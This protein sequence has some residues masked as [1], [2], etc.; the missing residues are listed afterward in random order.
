MEREK[1]LY[2]FVYRMLL[3]SIYNGTYKCK[4][5]LPSLAQ[6]CKEYKVGRNTIRCAL[7]QLQEDGYI[8]M[9]KGVQALVVFNVQDL[10]SNLK[11][12]QQLI[13]ARQMTKDVYE[14]LVMILPELSMA[15]F[16]KGVDHI[17]ELEEL[18]H[19]F[20]TDYIHSEL[21]L[22]HDMYRMYL[23]IF[24]YMGNPILSDLFYSLM[25]AAYQPLTPEE[26]SDENL[27]RSTTVIRTG[28]KLLIKF[29][30]KK[31]YFAAKGIVA[32]MC[33]AHA[34]RSLTYIDTL[35]HDLTPVEDTGFI[36]VCSREHEYLYTQVVLNI[37]NDI[38]LKNYCQDEIL[39]S[40]SELSLMYDVSERTIR[41]ALQILREYRVIVT[42]NGIGSKVAVH[43]F[44]KDRDILLNED[45]FNNLKAYRN[46]L[47][48]FQI[49]IKVVMPA[50]LKK[51]EKNELQQIA[52]EMRAECVSTLAP[53]ADR[54]FA[55]TNRCLYTIYKELE[56]TLNW[57]V[58]T[59]MLSSLELTQLKELRQQMMIALE[60]NTYKDIYRICN[61]IVCLDMERIQ[62]LLDEHEEKALT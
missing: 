12:R 7:L 48:I 37:L 41:K 9:Q 44:H 31:Q 45:V 34:K 36:W 20:H 39:P 14:T 62:Q 2:M 47:E 21:E 17:F 4:E 23:F 40:I 49:I 33:K 38:A 59:N 11:Y 24:N 51:M 32:M 50:T 28:A 1:N 54:V 19:R 10:N 6:L 42:I 52:K 22:V 15:C 60:T 55:K 27:Q 46:T 61:H 53:F 13:N 8:V 3:T 43:D 18:I 56:K 5:K 25:S 16:H 58:V 26:Q 30:R 35:C 57:C 29:V